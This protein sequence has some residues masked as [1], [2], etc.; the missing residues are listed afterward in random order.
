VVSG[1]GGG[2]RR[3]GKGS[4]DKAPGGG[5]GG[6]GG[7]RSGK[8]GK[9]TPPRGSKATPQGGSNAA[10]RSATPRGSVPTPLP[11]KRPAKKAPSPQVFLAVVIVLVLAGGGLLAYLA[12]RSKAPVATTVDP[13]LPPAVAKGYVLGRADAPV[14]IMEFADFECPAC[15]NYTV[16]TEPDVRKRIID[17]GLAQVTYYDYP[18]PQHKNTWV[19]S[20]AAA[21]A[22]DQGKFWE[23]HDRLF[24][25]QADWN[26]EATSDPEKIIKGYAKDLGL[27]M[28]RWQ[29]CV[30]QSAH[31]RDIQAN[32][33]EGDRHHVNETPTFVIGNKMIPGAVTYDELRAYVDSA[34][35]AA[36]PRTTA[37]R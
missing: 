6:G 22:N 34:R 13:N 26:G 31:Q 14:H 24:E 5:G 7:G 2:E 19:A 18:L 36:G 9:S 20:E 16:V 37:A 1:R 21:C 29:Q 12:G 28:N 8:Q 4:S 35:G 15:A 32:R 11:R 3:G 25:G 33:A 17:S 23:M 30:D 10:P 27:D